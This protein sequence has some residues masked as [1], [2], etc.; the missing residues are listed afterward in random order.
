[1]PENWFEKP[2][3]LPTRSSWTD[4]RFDE[5]APRTFL[6]R[7]A[8]LR[9]DSLEDWI[10]ARAPSKAVLADRDGL[11]LLERYAYHGMKQRLLRVLGQLPSHVLS[12]GDWGLNLVVFCAQQDWEDVVNVLIHRFTAEDFGR[13]AH[14]RTIIHWS[15]EFH[16]QSLPSL[17]GPKSKKWLDTT[18]HDGRTALHVAADYRNELACTALL[19]AGASCHIRDK[20]GQYPIHLAA[21]QGHRA[22]VGLLLKASMGI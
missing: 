19:Q 18:S 5:D 20:N 7:A 8:S 4:S 9:W 3:K 21:E 15:C 11:N 14:G 13:D 17:L 6:H 16:W 1:M 12:A 10:L 22:I 2:L